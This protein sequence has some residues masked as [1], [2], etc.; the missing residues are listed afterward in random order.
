MGNVYE[1][2][3]TL[4]R[5][6]VALK[7]I[8]R[9]LLENPEALQRFQAEVRNAARLAHPNIVTAYDAEQVADLH[10]LVMEYVEGIDLARV[11]QK[12]GPLPVMEACRLALQTALGL[13]HA[14][15]Q[16]MIHR[17]IK[18]QNLMLTAKG[19]VKILDFGLAR[20][21]GERTPAAGLT[22][23]GSFMGTPECVAPEQ[24]LDAHSAD[25]RS[26]I[27][28]LGCV[29]YYLLA[30]RLPFVEETEVKT[31]LAHIEK[32]PTPVH[33]CRTEVPEALSAV[34]TRMMAKDAGQRYQTPAEV[35]RALAPFSRVRQQKGSPPTTEPVAV[36][37]RTGTMMAS[38][39][40]PLYALKNEA[41]AASLAAPLLANPVAA[42]GSEFERLSTERAQ[43]KH[44]IKGWG[45][46]AGKGG[47]WWRTW[48]LPIV[49]GGGTLALI[50]LGIII[51]IKYRGS[52]GK[53]AE[54]SLEIKPS[55]P[56]TTAKVGEPGSK[57][58]GKDKDEA[59]KDDPVPKPEPGEPRGQTSVADTRPEIPP[60]PST[61][62][63]PFFSERLTYKGHGGPVWSVCF[64]PDGTR[65]ASGSEDRTVKV[66]KPGSGEAP[67]T[68]SYGPVF[69]VCF[70]SDGSRIAGGSL[71]ST[72]KV[73]DALKG[74]ETLFLKG[75]RR[76]VNAVRF[77]PD[78]TRIASA[79]ADQTVKVWDTKTG[80]CLLTYRK[81]E[82]P[83]D[84][85]CFSPD[86]LR[87][88]SASLSNEAVNVWD[89]T[90][91][92]E[93][94][95]IKGRAGCVR[96]PCFSPDS[97]Q[98]AGVCEDGTVKIW[99]AAT[100]QELK[101]LQGHSGTFLSVCFSQDGRHLVAG[102]IDGTIK[103]WNL[104]TG[105]E[106]QTL[107]GHSGP[108]WSVSFSPDGRQLASA[109]HDRT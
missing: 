95:A 90:T 101:T 63:L 76:G 70:S 74:Q 24:A 33:E 6:R 87:I 47:D 14:F 41:A 43:P 56:A 68:L 48:W 23:A 10:L 22:K 72:I 37:Q 18:P 32:E 28:S 58:Q 46:S 17:D 93:I 98:I 51:A 20:V 69:S 88:A 2:E 31:V 16:K 52:D 49:A 29:L 107:P 57:A 39:T 36:R 30:G 9:N 4:M 77:S 38:D 40:N 89:A 8:N 55:I 65:I 27:Y 67:L 13:Q 5:R 96:S 80:Q 44:Q 104:T 86:G 103:V 3:H 79:S 92:R 50:L 54:L 106:V 34:V 19:Q 94:L 61:Q 99:S 62:P 81:H 91:G 83:V 53:T 25:I 26:D 45:L 75:H 35:A 97:T 78:G 82:S 64:S 21:R 11:V 73:W 109:S 85:A 66:W 102:S 105:Q 59:K 71:D 12:R 1:A 15:E 7:V 108:V 60:E 100:G 84:S 42:P